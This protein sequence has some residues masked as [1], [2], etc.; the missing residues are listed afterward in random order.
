MDSLNLTH[1]D[2]TIINDA[3]QGESDR[4]VSDKVE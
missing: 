1:V 3:A 4:T 2:I